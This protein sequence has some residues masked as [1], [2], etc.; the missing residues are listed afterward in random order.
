MEYNPK[1]SNHGEDITLP[2]PLDGIRIVDFTW[3]RAGPWANRWLGALGADIIKIEWPERPDVIRNYPFTMPKEIGPG[4]NSSGQFNE[5]NANKRGISLNVRSPKGFELLKRLIAG[6]D[7]VIE[8]FSSRIM[9]NWGL[10]YAELEKIRPGIIYVS[11]AGFGHT[12]PSHHYV[13][14]GATAQA[15]SGL[16]FQSGLPGVQPA[17][18]G[19]SYLDDMGG[20]YGAICLVTALHHRERTGK[21][22]HV[23]LSQVANGITLQGAAFLDRTV[24]RRPSH[25][26]GFPPGNR[27]V[28]P[29]APKLNNYRGAIAAPHNAYRTAGG[30][31]NDWCTIVCL[32]DEEW[33]KLVGVMGSPKWAADIRFSTVDSRI[34]NQEEMDRGIEEWTLTLDKYEVMARCQ[35]VGVRAMPVQDAQDIVEHDAQLKAREVCTVLD[36]PLLGERRFQNAPFRMSKTP[37]KMH[38]SAPMIGQHTREVLEEVLGLD[39]EEIREGFED[40]T[41]WPTTMPKYPYLEESLR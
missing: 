3:I 1:V 40:G 23:D 9:Q 14:M 20:L 16:T 35:D 18:W 2:R 12:G 22:Q 4:L 17:G 41:F 29:G 30:G 28:W 34:D 25:R 19:W 8:N 7:V 38:S 6:C 5:S 31:Y 27:T 10:G 36:H 13:S 37:P 15:I 33:Q 11:M 39:I 24:N 21:G 32:S 26:E